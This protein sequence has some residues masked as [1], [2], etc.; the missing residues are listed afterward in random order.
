M[1]PI[2]LMLVILLPAFGA[3]PLGCQASELPASEKTVELPHAVLLKNEKGRRHHLHIARIVRGGKYTSGFGARRHPMGGGGSHHDGID[4]AARRGTPVRAAAGGYVAEIGWRGSYGRFIRI[5]HS[6]HVETA[7]AHLSRFARGLKAGRRVR[8]DAII[9]YVGT[10]GQSSG[11]H[12]HFELRRHGQPI[13][14][15]ALPH[16]ARGR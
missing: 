5:R 10:T 8:Q 16:A 1:T 4:I 6:D 12:L 9:G 11:P 3:L 2:R 15:L 13:D 7:Y 14:P